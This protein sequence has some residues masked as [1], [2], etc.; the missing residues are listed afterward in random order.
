MRRVQSSDA[1][2]RV[3]VFGDY[4][5]YFKNRV[6]LQLIAR[7]KDLAGKLDTGVTVLLLGE[8]VHQWAMEYVAHG[9]DTV[10]VVDLP[11]L[12]DYRAETYSGI[13]SQ[14]VE[15]YRP[16]I[17]LGGATRFG[18]ELFPRL[19]KRLDTGLSSDCV[20]LEIDPSDRGLVQIT[21]AFGGELLAEIVCPNR[22]PQMATVH[23]GT[24]K[25]LPHDASAVGCILYPELEIIPDERVEKIRSRPERDRETRL[26]DAPL[27]IVGGRGMGSK[28]QFET[29]FELADLLGAEVGATLPAIQAGWAAPD[30]LIGQTGRI[31]KPKLLISIGTSGA[32]QYTAGIRGAET[33]IAINRDPKASIFRMADLG[34]VGDGRTIVGLLLEEL[35]KR[36]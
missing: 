32:L 21:P 30:R 31:V 17:I 24:F 20:D 22:R 26:E 35:R 33:I 18:R 19:A 8:R 11:A 23:P 3:W 36:F 27:V 9:A 28:D 12:K 6:T 5:N 34:I 25:E 7:A 1:C 29:L 10:V 14:L 4:R 2:G 15:L 16:E 13:M